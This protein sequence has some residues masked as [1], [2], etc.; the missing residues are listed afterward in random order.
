MTPPPFLI[1]TL[2]TLVPSLWGTLLAWAVAQGLPQTF[3]DQAA[4]FAEG[5]LIPLCI[6]LYYVAVHWLEGRAWVPRALVVLLL[7]SSQAP[8]YGRH[9]ARENT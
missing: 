5:A 6:A 9:A 1:A 8:S 7:G 2:R 4:P 3:A